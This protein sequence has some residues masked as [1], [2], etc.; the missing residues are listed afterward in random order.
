MDPEFYAYIV[1]LFKKDGTGEAPC[2]EVLTALRDNP[3]RIRRNLEKMF[4]DLAT[5][6]FISTEKAVRGEAQ[7]GA[8]YIVTQMARDFATEIASLTTTSSVSA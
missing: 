6:Y 5:Q 7:D 1:N 8:R 3:D 4:V 2:V